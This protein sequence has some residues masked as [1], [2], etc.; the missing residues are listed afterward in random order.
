MQSL[1]VTE[2]GIWYLREC[3]R[4]YTGACA[5]FMLYAAALVYVCVFGSKREK[6]IFIPCSV[7]LLVTVYNPVS[8]VLLDRF[9]DV[10]SEY[11]RF[12]WLLP[13]IV[14][15]PYLCTKLVMSGGKTKTAAVLITAI[16]ILSGKFVYADGIKLA[17]NI[18]KMPPDL[19]SVSE[20]IHADSN[21]EYPKAFLEYE[22][23]MQMRQYDP[24]MQLTI[25]REDYLYV[26]TNDYTDEMLKDEEHPQYRL[27]AELIKLQ[28]VDPDAFVD[29]LEA[30]KTE[31]VVVIKDH[32]RIGYLEK[33]GLKKVAETSEHVIYKYDV[34][35][36]YVFELV[37]YSVVY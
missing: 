4:A 21:V 34:K 18:Y 29:A 23:N 14:L 32:P 25:D 31:Y 27:L 37:D 1:N 9:F 33:A 2:N 17:K 20:A 19:I 24:K 16:L 26:M 15:I 28:D 35:E 7:F 6:E 8:P 10:N 3:L 13:V 30:T 22:Y 11:Y 5:Y 36:P 12:F